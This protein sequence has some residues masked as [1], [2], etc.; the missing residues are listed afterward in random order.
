MHS[1]TQAF[2]RSQWLSRPLLSDS[3]P[4]TIK[5]VKAATA[6]V[7]A[8]TAQV[9][10]VAT[11]IAL[12]VIKDLEETLAADADTTTSTSTASTGTSTS[13]T[14]MESS[15]TGGVEGEGLVIPVVPLGIPMGDLHVKRVA[16]LPQVCYMCTHTVVLHVYY[17]MHTCVLRCIYIILPLILC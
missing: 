7:E 14:T 4:S 9:V 3:S 11:E 6:T 1:P 17:D 5:A 10:D 16:I 2:K 8:T 15:T 13:E 12:N